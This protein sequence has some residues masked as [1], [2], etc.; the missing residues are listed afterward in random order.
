M[1]QDQLTSHQKYAQLKLSCSFVQLSKKDIETTILPQLLR[2]GFLEAFNDIDQKL[3]TVDNLSIVISDC[4]DEVKPV[5]NSLFAVKAPIKAAEAP[6]APTLLQADPVKIET[7]NMSKK[8]FPGKADFELDLKLNNKELF[9]AYLADLVTKYDE[10]D[11]IIMFDRFDRLNIRGDRETCN[12]IKEDL[13]KDI[14]CLHLLLIETKHLTD[15]NE[16]IRDLPKEWKILHFTKQR[17]LEKCEQ[18]IA[19]YYICEPK[20]ILEEVSSNLEIMVF[21]VPKDIKKQFM[22]HVRKFTKAHGKQGPSSGQEGAF[23]TLA[24]E[25]FKD[26]DEKDFRD[27]LGDMKLGNKDVV[28]HHHEGKTTIRVADARH[29]KAVEDYVH[30]RQCVLVIK[31]DCE[32]VSK[33]IAEKQPT[34]KTA[35]LQLGVGYTRYTEP[36][37]FKVYLRKQEV[38]EEIINN[39]AQESTEK[40]HKVFYMLVQGMRS[41]VNAILSDFEQFKKNSLA[42][43]QQEWTVE[44]PAYLENNYVSTER[45]ISGY[46][47]EEIKK[48]E[49]YVT[50]HRNNKKGWVY[51]ATF[52]EEGQQAA[53]E[54]VKDK[55]TKLIVRGLHSTTIPGFAG[56]RDIRTIDALSQMDN[57]IEHDNKVMVVSFG[58]IG[59]VHSEIMKLIE[60]AKQSEE[61][62]IPINTYAI[63]KGK[64][65]QYPKSDDLKT[66]IREGRDGMIFSIEGLPHRVKP[67]L[68]RLRKDM[69]EAEGGMKTESFEVNREAYLILKNN[70]P[71]VEQLK[72][73]HDVKIDVVEKKYDNAVLIRLGN[74]NKLELVADGLEAIGDSKMRVYTDLE[75]INNAELNKE[76]ASKKQY[77]NKEMNA[78]YLNS[79]DYP[80]IND[81]LE[82]AFSKKT[83]ICMMIP[84]KMEINAAIGAVIG[85][86]QQ[87]D[88]QPSITLCVRSGNST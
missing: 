73:E 9:I 58:N 28:V 27:Y 31:A 36:E 3:K 8:M 29:N 6:A 1:P 13:K 61:V 86:L 17:A 44:L 68:D 10:R 78:M 57:L 76:S 83:A 33:F 40:C 63:V 20:L 55:F 41:T 53:I 60:K 82:A 11:G 42:A 81:V 19:Q 66:K 37:L 49:K 48:I 56:L 85:Y 79:K 71:I 80:T 87:N 51:I 50:L 5:F 2:Q 30:N 74:F 69:E 47:D 62:F 7:R 84:N 65:E 77:Y 15:V 88:D 24:T 14:N 75:D 46:L 18:L 38:K 45:L 39:T 16:M 35:V 25:D 43:N 23:F 64:L 4:M 54:L 59:D 21:L 52:P 26:K 72:K 12:K 32:I 34:Y 22:R 70:V 67:I